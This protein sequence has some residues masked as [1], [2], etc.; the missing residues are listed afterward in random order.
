MVVN[1]LPHGVEEAEEVYDDPYLDRVRGE[2][3]EA[4]IEYEVH[5][6]VRGV[7]PAED[8]VRIA[9]ETRAEFIVIGRDGAAA[10]RGGGFG[11]TDHDS[12]TFLAKA[13]QDG[14]RLVRRYLRIL[15]HATQLIR[16]DEALGPPALDQRLHLF[17][18]GDLGR[19]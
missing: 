3:V 7:E 16:C 15:E 8:V 1:A 4:G 11:G 17:G 19:E 9:E 14:L 10:F 5:Q 6:L 13:A 18:C 12:H 2:L